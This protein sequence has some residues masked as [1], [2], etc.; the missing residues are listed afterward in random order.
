[1]PLV[2]WNNSYSLGIREFDEH[3][4]HL[5]ELLNKTFDAFVAYK[6]MDKLGTILHELMAYSEYHFS[7][8]VRWMFRYDF[9]HYHEHVKQH[10]DFSREMEAFHQEFIKG[11]DFIAPGVLSYLKDWLIHHILDS[12]AK[13]AQFECA[14]EKPGQ[15]EVCPNSSNDSRDFTY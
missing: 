10:E 13:L 11:N 12:D 7:E 3:H 4:K 2:Q 15:F 14:A 9:P 1:M 8:E 6:T 5:V